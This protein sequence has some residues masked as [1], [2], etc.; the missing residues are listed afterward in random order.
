M[1]VCARETTALCI[2]FWTRVRPGGPDP[3]RMLRPGTENVRMTGRSAAGVLCVLYDESG[4][5]IR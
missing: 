5:V 1:S 2:A 4:K 3:R